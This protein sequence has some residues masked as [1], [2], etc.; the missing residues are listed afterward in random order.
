MSLK[1]IAML[2][3][4]LS[5]VSMAVQGALNTVMGKFIG[6][7]ETTFIVHIVGTLVVFLGLFVFKLGSGSF[8]NLN[9]APWYAFIGGV[10]GVIIVYSVVYSISNLG[11][12]IATTVIITGQIIT[13]VL[14]DHF[15]LFGL[16]KICFSWTKVLGILFLSLGVKFMLN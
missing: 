16:D 5:G 9:R 14:I 7:L 13:A 8:E 6:V 15:G 12:A 2:I 4:V 11:V 3:A 1:I 10:F